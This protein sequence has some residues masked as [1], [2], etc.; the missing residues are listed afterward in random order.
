MCDC[1]VALGET[2]ARGATLFGKN[3]DRERDEAQP[4]RFFP[5]AEHAADAKTRCT[6]IEVPQARETAAVLGTGPFWCWGLEQGVNDHGVLIGNES[7]FTREEIELP[8]A[9]LLGMDLVRLA[10]ERCRTARE[11]V[12]GMGAWIEQF[13]QGG[14]GWLHIPLG[15]SNGFMIADRTEAWSLQTSS[16]RWVA[17]R[18]GGLGAI[19]N[20]PSIGDDWELGSEDVERFAVERGWWS[21]DQGRLDFE[22]AYRS[23]KLFAAHGSDG[24]LRRSTT[25][26]ERDRG[27]LAESEL[28]TLLR[29]HGGKSVPPASDKSEE[30]YFTLCAHNEVQ[31][32]TAASMVVALDRSIRWFALGSP[33][34]NVYLPLSFDG[35]IPEVLT[36]AGRE[37][38]P[39]SAWWSFKALQLETERDFANR[40]PR[41]REALDALEAEWL[42]QGDA[43]G[44]STARMEEATAR[45]LET[46]QRLLRE[47]ERTPAPSGR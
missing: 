31:G 43:G 17:K 29:D 5:R 42:D 22:Q 26:L 30:A 21:S 12:E 23:T 38:E 34:T 15:Y 13:G 24:R 18:I 35:K 19:S 44:D 36:R 33:C 47:F 16:R 28:F 7:V 41:V 40:L 37:P 46:S 32:D 6:Y 3:S 11:A 1:V 25:L 45:A 14:K 9:G 10:L 27:E 2:T 4:L 39:G 20:H 8:E